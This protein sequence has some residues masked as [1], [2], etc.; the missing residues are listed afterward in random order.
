MQFMIHIKIF[1]RRNTKKRK[2]RKKRK[3][4]IKKQKYVIKSKVTC[5]NKE[6][7]YQGRKNNNGRK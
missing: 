1:P 7:S 4:S 5:T 3:K 2:E 6:H